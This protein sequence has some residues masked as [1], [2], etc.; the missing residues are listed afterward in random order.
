MADIRYCN[1]PPQPNCTSYFRFQFDDIR[2]GNRPNQLNEAILDTK[3]IHKPNPSSNLPM[4]PT[5][6]PLI[7]PSAQALDRETECSPTTRLVS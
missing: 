2:E 6:P 3:P 7:L 4:L 1:I 5:L